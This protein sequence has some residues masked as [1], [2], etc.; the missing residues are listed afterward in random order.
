MVAGTPSGLSAMAVSSLLKQFVTGALHQS[1]A[2]TLTVA[3]EICKAD[4]YSRGETFS[5]DQIKKEVVK[6]Y[7]EM[8]GVVDPQIAVAMAQQKARNPQKP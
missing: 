5:D 1:A 4:H 6:I 2:A 8:M 3:F 7:S